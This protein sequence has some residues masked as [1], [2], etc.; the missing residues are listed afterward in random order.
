MI[1]LDT[2]PQHQSRYFH[3]NVTNT[4]TLLRTLFFRSMFYNL[5]SLR[6][7]LSCH[8]AVHALFLS[9]SDRYL[10]SFPASPA[11]FR[12]YRSVDLLLPVDWMIIPAK[13]LFLESFAASLGLLL[14]VEDSSSPP[15][16][17]Y[18]MQIFDAA[19]E[20][21]SAGLEIRVRELYQWG[22][23]QFVMNAVGDKASVG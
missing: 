16:P 1:Y 6:I 12:P 17:H 7:M 5:T 23:I 2:H 9:A 10:P 21:R 3:P 14:R 13:D 18:L 20:I 4:V 19:F 22:E 11:T 8:R 15:S